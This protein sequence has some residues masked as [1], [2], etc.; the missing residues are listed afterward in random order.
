MMDTRCGAKFLQ[1]NENNSRNQLLTCCAFQTAKSRSEHR[2]KEREQGDLKSEFEC[3]RKS[4][5]TPIDV[6]LIVKVL[7]FLSICVQIQSS[8]IVLRPS[9]RVISKNANAR[10]STDAMSPSAPTHARPATGLFHL[11]F[12]YS[13]S[14]KK[15]SQV[16][17]TKK[18]VSVCLRL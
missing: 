11:A 5:P 3:T 15:A 12:L 17:F 16:R 18:L 7:V 4:E 14:T 1:R 13:A 9:M 8:E 6:K 10:P 2:L